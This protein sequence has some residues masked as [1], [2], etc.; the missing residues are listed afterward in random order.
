MNDLKLLKQFIQD[1]ISYL[2][3]EIK[4]TTKYK[5]IVYHPNVSLSRTY[6]I[7]VYQQILDR[8]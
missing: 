3:E 7:Y 5:N 1:Q 2:E 6:E 8:L 4:H